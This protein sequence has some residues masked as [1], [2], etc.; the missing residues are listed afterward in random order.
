ML[1]MALLR[2]KTES[3]VVLGLPAGN[4]A[5]SVFKGIPY[6]AP[7]VGELRWR[8][9]QP[10]EPWEGE[11]EAY[12]YQ[13]VNMHKRPKKGSF[14]AKEFAPYEF[15]MSEDCLYLNIWTPAE[16]ADEKLPV[17]MWFH[18]GDSHAAKQAFDGE[19]FAKRGVIMIT[20][21][22]R[23]GI[24]GS[25]SHKELSLES[26]RETGHYTSGNYS[27]LD[28]VAAVKWVRRNIAAFGG[29]PDKI[30]VFG[31]SAGGTAT[32]RLSST[33]LLKG[34]LFGAIMQ[35][36]GG[37]DIR[38]MSNVATLEEAEAY[39][40][41]LFKENGI[42]SV[43]EARAL[44]AETVMNLGASGPEIGMS[45]LNMKADG[46]SL[47]YTPEETALKNLHQDIHYMIG[48][49]KHEGF[50]YDG[51]KTTL[52]AFKKKSAAMFGD[53]ADGYVEAACVDS[54]AYANLIIKNENGDVKLA[55]CMSW[56]EL[57]NDLKRPAPY[58]YIFT[59]EAPGGQG[60]GAFHSGEH[61]YVFQTMFRMPRDYDGSDY[62]LSNTMCDYWTNFCK[63]GDPNGEGLPKWTP[64]EDMRNDP[65]MMELGL[66]VGMVRPPE[67]P[68]SKFIKEYVYNK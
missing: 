3:G 60:V 10:V 62:D 5:I 34:E 67:T 17:A 11:K 22:F 44:D 19:A 48:C 15:P 68:V 46:Y 41:S 4:Q 31:Q 29:D 30:T 27:L 53:K 13:F 65:W 63:T 39:G 56:V 28:Q 25:L 57:Q 14:Y 40:E 49:T 7:P 50:A 32:Q 51:P 2:V 38:Y 12:A 66:R 59:K 8:A 18:G 21:G 9:P 55:T 58:V 54:D 26:E 20:V 52:E 64:T 33:P 6:A 37:L 36:A 61:A 42:A 45:Y 35:S 24:F 23:T 16:K 47:L 1:D 43:A